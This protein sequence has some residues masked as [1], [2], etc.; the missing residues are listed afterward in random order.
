MSLN[1]TNMMS[2]MTELVEKYDMGEEGKAELIS[3]LNESLVLIS[4][5]ILKSAKISN[6]SN[7]TQKGDNSMKRYKSK[8]AEDYA[9]EHNIEITE[10]EMNEISKKDVENLIREKTKNSEKMESKVSGEK[11][12][13]VEK[14]EVVKKERVICCGINKKGEACKSTGTINPEGAKK[15]YCFRHA[16]DWKSFECSSDSSSDEESKE[17]VSE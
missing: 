10:F 8:K 12:E 11:V 17:L 1:D 5:E 9:E 4:S 3:I 6:K 7:K 16:E 2:R 13:K 14:R 15:K